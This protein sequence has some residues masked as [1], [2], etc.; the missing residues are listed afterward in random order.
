MSWERHG[1]GR[2]ELSLFINGLLGGTL[3]GFLDHL[4]HDLAEVA[5]LAATAHEDGGARV[6]EL[7]GRQG[8]GGAHRLDAVVMLVLGVDT[9]ADELGAGNVANVELGVL[10]VELG[11]PGQFERDHSGTFGDVVGMGDARITAREG[12]MEANVGVF[13]SK[14]KTDRVFIL[15]ERNAGDGVMLHHAV[16]LVLVEE[17]PSDSEDEEED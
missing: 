11:I 14:R 15:G 12:G 6:A 5:E 16:H 3:D 7:S 17:E 4:A 9:K 10:H 1:Y 13:I 2:K 8:D